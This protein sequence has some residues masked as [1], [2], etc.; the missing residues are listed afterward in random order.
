M[1]VVTVPVVLPVHNNWCL[2]EEGR[3]RESHA[4]HF[5]S[6]RSTTILLGSVGGLLIHRPSEGE[7]KRQQRVNTKVYTIDPS[8]VWVV[9]SLEDA[10]CLPFLPFHR[11]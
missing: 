6:L 5:D 8:G 10:C 7:E 3:E 11:L 9:G 2:M 4:G 1:V